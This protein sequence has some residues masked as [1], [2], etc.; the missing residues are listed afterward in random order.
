MGVLQ[1]EVG[2]MEETSPAL[3]DR[4]WSVLV[5]TPQHC[6]EP[7]WAWVHEAWRGTSVA[8]A[9]ISMTEEKGRQTPLPSDGG[10]SPSHQPQTLTWARAWHLRMQGLGRTRCWEM[11]P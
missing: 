9:Q 6:A 5:R 3:H 2:W 10:T 1:M 8:L 4:H 11:R 7:D